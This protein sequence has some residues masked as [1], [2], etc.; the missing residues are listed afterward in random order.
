MEAI[1]RLKSLGKRWEK[2]G[3]KRLYISEHS[4][5]TVFPD[6]PKYGKFTNLWIDVEGSEMGSNKYPIVHFLE[7]KGVNCIKTK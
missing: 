7:E 5:K 2:N 3:V 1:K 6:A 4:L